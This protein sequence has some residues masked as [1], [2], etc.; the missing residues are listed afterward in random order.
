MD[1]PFWMQHPNA[2]N[3]RFLCL[4]CLECRLQRLG[5]FKNFRLT[6]AVGYGWLI[7]VEMI[8]T[9]PSWCLL[10]AKWGRT[11]FFSIPSPQIRFS[12]VKGHPVSVQNYD[13][14]CPWYVF[15][16]WRASWSKCHVSDLMLSSI[17]SVLWPSCMWHPNMQ[18]GKKKII[19]MNVYLFGI[20]I[21]V[22]AQLAWLKSRC[23]VSCLFK[24]CNSVCL[25]SRVTVPWWYT[26]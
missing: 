5:N 16:L 23:N 17:V 6:S 4:Y 24:W 9:Q 10:D 14:T 21:R 1:F 20:Y 8:F 7:E 15:V 3:L 11:L 26:F 18:R 12:E 19:I 2:H 13:C 25:L 22:L